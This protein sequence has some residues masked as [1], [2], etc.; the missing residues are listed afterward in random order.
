[1]AFHGKKQLLKKPQAQR[2]E[3][4]AAQV[5]RATGSR[6]ARSIQS[7]QATRAGKTVS[8]KLCQSLKRLEAHEVPREIVDSTLPKFYMDDAAFS[9]ISDVRK[10]HIVIDNP[11]TMDLLLNTA[12]DA[13]NF[14]GID[15]YGNWW[16]AKNLE[17][18]TQLWA[19]AR[20]NT[21][22]VFNG[23]LNLEKK[24]F[25]KETGLSS[26]FKP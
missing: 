19:E 26:Q 11:A 1:V 4:G 5:K 20:P 21:G 17:N 18:G 10:G 6:P 16:F 12:K 13:K 2:V 24:T 14:L 22:K 23:G 25:N 15:K 9:H 8:E 3:Q 7:S